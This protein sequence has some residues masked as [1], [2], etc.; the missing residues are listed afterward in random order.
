[1]MELKLDM[2]K[3]YDRIEWSF[4]QAELLSMGFPDQMI[5]LI[6]KCISAL[7]YQI[8][9]NGQPNKSFRP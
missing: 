6:M 4:V 5:R 2:S 9:I 3:A 8:L 1:M 7:S